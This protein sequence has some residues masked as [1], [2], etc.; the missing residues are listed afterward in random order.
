MIDSQTD[1]AFYSE[2]FNVCTVWLLVLLWIWKITTNKIVFHPVVIFLTDFLFLQRHLLLLLIALDSLLYRSANPYPQL[3]SD[4]LSSHLTTS[5]SQVYYRMKD[6]ENVRQTASH[7]QIYKFILVVD[8]IVST[9]VYVV[10]DSRW[11]WMTSWMSQ[12]FKNWS[13]KNG[14]PRQAKGDAWRHSKALRT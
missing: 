12:Q 10:N 1:T 6:C 7:I 9:R 14:M 4:L 8:I 2:G 11:E 3:N 5:P 13:F